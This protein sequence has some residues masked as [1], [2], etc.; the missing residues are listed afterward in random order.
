MGVVQ[1]KLFHNVVPYLVG[2]TAEA[3]FKPVA[4]QGFL[5]A[6]KDRLTILPAVLTLDL[7]PKTDRIVIE[8][9]KLRKLSAAFTIIEK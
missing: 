2:T 3:F 8:V 4:K 6:R 7:V 9:E 1:V 5:L